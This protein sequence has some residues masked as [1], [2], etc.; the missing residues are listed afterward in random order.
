MI[1]AH[2]CRKDGKNAWR[3]MLRDHG[4]TESPNAGWP[5][6]AMAGA[7]RT[8]LEK[9]ECYCL[10]NANNPLSPQLIT[11]GVKLAGMSALLWVLVYLIG[12][13]M[14]FVFIA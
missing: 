7:L 9:A 13:V 1:A 12:G 4:K 14:Y 6:S 10:G 11:S 8:Q 5:M 2:V 3:V